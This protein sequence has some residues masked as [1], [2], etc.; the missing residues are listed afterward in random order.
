[1]LTPSLKSDIHQLWNTFRSGGISNPLTAIEQISYLIF[2]KRLDDLDRQNIMKAK[3]VS[4][5]SYQSIF[6]GKEELRRSY[7][8]QLP[9]EE[10]L[11]HVRDIV[12]P[13]VKTLQTGD[14]FSGTLSDATFLIPKAS[15]LVTA[16]TIIENLHISE[17]NEDTSGDIYEY[18]INE[19]AT[20]GKNGQFRTPRHIIQSII[21]LV[22]PT[23]NDVICD[24][25]CG[26]AGFLI[27]TYK[28]IIKQNSSK[29]A[30]FEDESGTHYPGD[31]LNEK[32]WKKLKS[33]TLQGFDFDTTMVRI[34]NMNEI[35]HGVTKPNIAYKDTLGKG[36]SHESVYDVILANPPFKG[37]ID[38]GDLNPDFTL[39]TKKTELL[40]LELIYHKLRIGG[41]CAVIVPDG[42]L[43]GSSNAHKKIRELLVEQS[44][45]KAVISLPSGVFKPY[46]G[47]STAVLI[48]TKGDDTQKVWFYDLQ[49]DGYSL[50]D[51]RNP[52]SDN[53]LPD[54]IEK[55]K[56]FV[57]ARLYNKQP[58]KG[59]KRFRVDKKEIKEYKYDLSISKY[60][61][62]EY[63]PVEYEKPKVLI[64]QIKEIEKKINDELLKIEE[65][66]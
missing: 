6:Q 63:V 18:L 21:E 1:M 23:K 7:W 27:N 34:A 20:A 58:E 33:D 61:K 64:K 48:F 10:M 56:K 47:V 4:N 15:L 31:L 54:L 60:K 5:F 50:D 41:R 59:E 29:D 46:A 11:S 66:L 30:I 42:V 26:T 36:F 37:S 49:A 22:N 38:K 45:L 53:D 52:I 62:I 55:Y 3:K 19:I 28:R 43:F 40:F 57:D 12:F 13:F 17:Q 65:M 16:V 9:A 44:D 24:P 32:D 2:M 51:K 35:M 14:G 8:M 25:A 39:D